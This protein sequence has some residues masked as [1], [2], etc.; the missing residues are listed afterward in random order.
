VDLPPEEA[1]ELKKA[2]DSHQL[3]MIFLLA[4]TSTDERI[5]KVTEL[6]SGFVYYVSITGVTGARENL[7]DMMDV[8]IEKI[9]K[10]TDLP[11]GVGFGV[12]RPEHVRGICAFADA[13]IV[14]SAIIKEVV[15]HAG[16][17][18]MLAKVASFVR[19]LKQATRR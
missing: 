1:A 18:D 11:V 10:F 9:R 14:G 15:A 19:G 2:A 12:S 17:P 4:P 5:R 6:A 8:Y 7:A 3:D 16:K 13:V